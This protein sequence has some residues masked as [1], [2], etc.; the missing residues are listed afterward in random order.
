MDAPTFS[1]VMEGLYLLGAAQGLFLAAVLASRPRQVVAHRLLA[2]FVLVFSADLAMAVYHASGASA[3]HPA[4][5]GLD[6]PIALLYG[7]LLYLYVRAL[8]SPSAALRRT[9]AWHAVPFLA[10]VAF[11]LPF[12]LRPGPEKLALMLDPGLSFQ[13]RAMAV[14][15]PLKLVHGS[16]YLALIVAC[17][18]RAGGG[19]SPGTQRWLR[20]LTAGVL[21]MLLAS[22][23]FYVLGGTDAVG[24][25]DAS[26]TDDLTLLTVTV[27]VYALGYFGLRR[28]EDEGPEAP[29]AIPTEP[30]YAR[31]GM[32]PEEA[33]RHAAA[34]RALMEAE[35][36]HRR[37]DLTLPDLAEALGISPH[38]LTE[39]L[40]TQL[41]QT[42]YE[43]VNGYRVADV[44]ARLTDPAYAH[45]TVLAIGL[46]AGFNA[47]SSFNAAFKRTT[48]M[49]P[50]QYRQRHT[51]AV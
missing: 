23:L 15:N 38:N 37:G 30:A 5:I 28:P 27:F 14:V 44:Q 34:L 7:P 40:S 33:A 29:A 47:K 16:V 46:D 1:R 31:S 51:E 49:T 12:Y 18:R 36:P 50:S 35:H 13:T 2:A 25:D 17:V 43:V 26:V 24:L 20:G 21:A 9:D 22:A 39:V 32:R 48:G 19:A 42:F 10:L 8:T 3:R 45:W 6:L 11:L 41:G 4:L